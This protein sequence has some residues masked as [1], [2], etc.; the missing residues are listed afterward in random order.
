[1]LQLKD[2]GRSGGKGQYTEQTDCINWSYLILLWAILAVV[3]P[4]LTAAIACFYIAVFFTVSQLAY[5]LLA[6]TLRLT[7]YKHRPL[8][9]IPL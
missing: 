1:M 8:I 7:K 2:K 3:G 5:S 9:L 6:K 4:F